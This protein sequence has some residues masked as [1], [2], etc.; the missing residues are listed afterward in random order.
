MNTESIGV[1]TD[2]SKN[3]VGLT[4]LDILVGYTIGV[5]ASSTFKSTFTDNKEI[6]ASSLNEY[7]VS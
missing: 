1:D 5:S 7:T 3:G 4:T 2:K 6:V